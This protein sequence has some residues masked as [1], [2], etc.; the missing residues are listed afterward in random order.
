MVARDFAGEPL[1]MAA[2]RII[3]RGGMES[4]TVRALAAE[5]G[6]SVGFMRHYYAR[7]SMLLACAYELVADAQ[8]RRTE[9]VLWARTEPLFNPTP[10][11]PLGPPLAAELLARCLDLGEDQFLIGA[12]MSFQSFAQHDGDVGDAVWRYHGR[13]Q[14]VAMKVLREAG[15]PNAA[16]AEEAT[17]LWVL[18]MGL[19]AL[20][21]DLASKDSDVTSTN[22]THEQVVAVLCRHLEAAVARNSA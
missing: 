10:A 4:L 3:G 6:C 7:K 12:Q 18:M 16:L 9:E 13:L 8:L 21:P 5:A 20:L 19:T 22:I 11:E 1:F 17:D 2:A 15:V 14:E